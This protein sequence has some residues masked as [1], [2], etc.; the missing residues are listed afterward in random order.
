MWSLI[1]GFL[2]PLGI[3]LV[4]QAHWPTAFRAI[5]GFLMCLAAAAGTVLIQ[6]GSWDWHKWVQ[7]ALLI[8]VTAIATYES[9]W[10][11]TGVATA[12]EHATSPVY[13]KMGAIQKPSTPAEKPVPTQLPAEPAKP[14]GNQ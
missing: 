13:K 8:F 14:K 5:A 1:V 12:I 7:S 10:K 6:V 11:K 2:L 4:Q 3:A 9:F